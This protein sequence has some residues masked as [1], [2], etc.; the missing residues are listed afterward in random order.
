MNT[1][2][3]KC[4]DS[5][6]LKSLDTPSTSSGLDSNLVANSILCCEYF[7]LVDNSVLPYNTSESM[8]FLRVRVPNVT[9]TSS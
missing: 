5:N 6:C 4:W 3:L 8:M 7:Q 2:S 9:G 1:F